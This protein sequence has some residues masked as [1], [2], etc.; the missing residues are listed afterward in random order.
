MIQ[1][2]RERRVYLIIEAHAEADRDIDEMVVS[3]IVEWRCAA[4]ALLIRLGA[5]VERLELSMLHIDRVRCDWICKLFR[6][7]RTFQICQK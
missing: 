2:D 5:V 1:I 6:R 7:Q 4:K 3:H